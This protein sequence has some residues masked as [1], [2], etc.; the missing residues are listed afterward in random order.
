MA[1]LAP[2]S[3]PAELAG[4]LETARVLVD[5]ELDRRLRPSGDDPGRLA[6]AMHYAATGP[7]KRLRPALVIAACEACGGSR[8][9]AMPA[10]AAIEMLHAYTLVHDDLPA[11]DDDDERR[12]RPTVHV[13]FGDAIA[14]LAGDGLLT[15]A[16]G[17]LAELGPRAA[18]AVSVLA[19]RAGA[20]EL[21][22]G[23]AID[24]TGSRESLR[25]LAAIEHMHAAKTGALFAAAAELGAIAAGATTDTRS[26]LATF[27][28]SIG[29]AFQHA[30]DRDDAEL[31]EHAA[32][33][34]ERMR[35]LCS[36]ARQAVQ[37][38]GSAVLDSLASWIAARA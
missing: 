37:V 12:G 15:A 33:A 10:A 5:A 11:M 23:Q 16:F 17:A 7:G 1:T 21:L 9:Q 18:D 13:V 3:A 22:R 35:M 20:G 32:R 24:L 38:L 4:F 14:I 19:R 26:A 28:M 36:E 27:G 30:D 6:E 29:I 31:T 25:D 2:E 34:A 8:A